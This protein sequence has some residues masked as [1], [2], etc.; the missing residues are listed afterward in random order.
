MFKIE[1]A[2]RL[3]DCCL[4]NKMMVDP[5]A[6]VCGY[7]IC[8]GHIDKMIKDSTDKQKVFK[9]EMCNEEH[10]VPNGGFVVK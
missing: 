9:C 7:T 2:K 4:D 8:K 1:K 3:F 5:I 10:C 6:L